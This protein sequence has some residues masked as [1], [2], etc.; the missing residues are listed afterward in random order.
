MKL[1][2]MPTYLGAGRSSMFAKKAVLKKAARGSAKIDTL[3]AVIPKNQTSEA[4][5]AAAA[6]VA[7]AAAA[8]AAATAAD[9]GEDGDESD[10][11]DLVHKTTVGTCCT[12]KLMSL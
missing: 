1:K 10:D 7:A 12:Q 9:T 8:P 2:A 5:A 11:E 4:V 6:A 3:F